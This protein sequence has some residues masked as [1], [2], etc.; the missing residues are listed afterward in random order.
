MLNSASVSAPDEATTYFEDLTTNIQQGSKWFK[1]NIH[2][3]KMEA[4]V[5][6]WMI[7]AFGHSLGNIAI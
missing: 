5:T 6:S 7:D 1:E 3:K 4:S 2:P